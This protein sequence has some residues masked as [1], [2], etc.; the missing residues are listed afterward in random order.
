[1]IHPRFGTIEAI[2]DFMENDKKFNPTG[3]PLDEIINEIQQPLNE[4]MLDVYIHALNISD[5]LEKFK[6]NIFRVIVQKFEE[7]QEEENEEM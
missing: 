2:K 7:L 1:M 3:V 6:T 4:D 5:T